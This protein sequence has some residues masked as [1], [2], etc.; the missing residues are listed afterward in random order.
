LTSSAEDR[1][2][3]ADLLR[4]VADGDSAAFAAIYDRHSK[5][6]FGVLLRILRSRTDAEDIL[7]ETFIQIWQRASSF[8]PA[9]G[10]ALSWLVL[11]AR[12]RA[13]DRL[14]SRG[15]RARVTQEMA[16]EPG[17]SASEPTPAPAPN[18]DAHIVRRALSE[19]SEPQR[20]ALQLAYF[21]GLSQAEI[22]E[23]LGKP[24]G[25]VKTHTRLGLIHLR[26]LLRGGEESS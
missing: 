12:S 24:L 23:R 2:L 14:R 9:R 19:I 6:L 26:A 3:D 8:D 11:L 18:E 10:Q 5:I 25:T 1:A 21:E 22:A 13:L 16:V 7:Q 4:R 15:T 20:E 17:G